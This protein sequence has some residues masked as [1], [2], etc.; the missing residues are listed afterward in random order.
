VAI[1]ASTIDPT[2]DLALVSGGAS[3]TASSWGSYGGYDAIP[4]AAIDGLHDERGWGGTQGE[5]DWLKIDLGSVYRVQT[6]RID[7]GYHSLEYTYCL[8]EDGATWDCP[9]IV[10]SSTGDHYID[11]PLGNIETITFPA[12][13]AMRFIRID[14]LSTNAPSSHIWE[15]MLDEV[16]AYA[17]AGGDTPALFRV[18]SAGNVLADQAF[19]GAAFVTGAADVAEWVT[20]SEPAEPGDVVEFDPTAPRQYRISQDGCSSLVAGVISTVPGVALGASLAASEKALLALI[21]IVPVK[22]TNEGGAIQP[23]DLLVTS[24]NP[25][26]AMRWA[27][28]DPCQCGLVGK[29]LEPMTDDTGV[30]L[31]LLTAH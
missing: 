19:F 20:M 17:E 15:A 29:A 26:H 30:I 25:G 18:D 23:G 14:I 1:F 10:I 27:G 22:A 31:V 7:N 11:D 13:T 8:S 4:N 28:L 16:E 2:E 21:G 5:G 3:A 12:G 6:L 24:S 9:T